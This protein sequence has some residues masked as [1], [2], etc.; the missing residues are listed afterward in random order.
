MLSSEDVVLE[1]F[2]SYCCPCRGWRHPVPPRRRTGGSC[3]PPDVA[4]F[5]YAVIGVVYAVLLGFSAIIVWE[6]YRQ[7]RGSRAGGERAG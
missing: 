1:P 6:Q 4:G 3:T 5:I 7:A 2:P